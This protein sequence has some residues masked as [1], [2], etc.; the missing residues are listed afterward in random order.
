[1]IT[2]VFQALQK[3]KTQRRFSHSDIPDQGRISNSSASLDPTLPVE[4]FDFGVDYDG[5]D[6]KE[7]SDPLTNR[8]FKVVYVNGLPVYL[9]P[10]PS[11]S[12]TTA[13]DSVLIDDESVIEDDNVSIDTSCSIVFSTASMSCKLQRKFYDKTD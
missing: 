5:V 4:A 13:R 3:K 7:E 1:M 11:R 10:E 2:R 12:T 9:E 8:R 6:A